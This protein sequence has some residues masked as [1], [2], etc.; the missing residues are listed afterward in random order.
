MGPSL[1]HTS[2]SNEIQATMSPLQSQAHLNPNLGLKPNLKAQ[3]TNNSR[4]LGN[5]AGI[6]EL[7]VLIWW[8]PKFIVRR[9]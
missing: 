9:L 2:P 4:I 7:C 3:P 8:V 1:K 6:N 5:H